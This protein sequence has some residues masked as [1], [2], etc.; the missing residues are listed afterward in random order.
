VDK[1]TEHAMAADALELA[2]EGDPKH[3]AGITAVADKIKERA[4]STREA[5][6][7]V[8]ALRWPPSPAGTGARCCSEQ[9]TPALLWVVNKAVMKLARK[10]SPSMACASPWTSEKSSFH[11]RV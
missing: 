7:V 9:L 8:Q 11:S 2:L 3:A 5:F 4:D 1:K 10:V 6:G